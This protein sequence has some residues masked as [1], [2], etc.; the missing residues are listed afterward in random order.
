MWALNSLFLYYMYLYSCCDLEPS[1]LDD[2]CLTRQGHDQ[3]RSK[4]V[5]MTKYGHYYPLCGD[6]DYI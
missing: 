4:L 3:I 5:I 2:R 1:G 6:S